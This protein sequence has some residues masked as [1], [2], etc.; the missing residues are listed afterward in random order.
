MYAVVRVTSVLHCHTQVSDLFTLTDHP[1]FLHSW[2][3]K[4]CT[5]D[6]SRISTDTFFGSNN[7]YSQR[8][9]THMEN[10]LSVFPFFWVTY[11]SFYTATHYLQA[12]VIEM[13]LMSSA[14]FNQSM[15]HFLGY[16]LLKVFQCGLLP[17]KCSKFFIKEGNLTL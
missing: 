13:N 4:L 11:S 8:E 12:S 9:T 1:Y 5:M 3:K 6:S 7:F 2:M 16:T 17:W 15:M 10:L 14:K